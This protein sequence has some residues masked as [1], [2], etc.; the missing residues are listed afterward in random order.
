MHVCRPSGTAH[1]AGA[2]KI[3]LV[4]SVTFRGL[5]SVVNKEDAV[6]STLSMVSENASAI[7][8]V[9]NHLGVSCWSVYTC[10][11]RSNVPSRRS[12]G[13]MDMNGI[14]VVDQGVS[15]PSTRWNSIADSRREVQP[16]SSSQQPTPDQGTSARTHF[17]CVWRLDALSQPHQFRASPGTVKMTSSMASR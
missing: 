7:A 12:A 10:K 3:W 1:I 9:A 5:L 15:R 17:R 14:T 6:P 11:E 13:M 4:N 16:A 2:D 8:D